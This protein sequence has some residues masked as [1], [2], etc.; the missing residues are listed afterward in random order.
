[1]SFL[2]RNAKPSKAIR[3]GLIEKN[4]NAHYPNGDVLAILI[5]GEMDFAAYR[6]FRFVAES[7]GGEIDYFLTQILS[8]QSSLHKIRRMM[9]FASNFKQKEE[10]FL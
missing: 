9:R 3:E 2:L 7:R 6:Q 8:T 4:G 5:K 10:R 1:M